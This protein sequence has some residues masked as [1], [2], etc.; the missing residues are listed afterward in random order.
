MSLLYIDKPKIDLAIT[1][2]VLQA[3]EKGEL[4]AQF[5][6]NALNGILIYGNSTISAKLI[7]KALRQHINLVFLY[8]NRPY[9]IFPAEQTNAMLRLRQYEAS[10]CKALCLRY[11]QYLVKS[12]T[13]RQ[14]LTLQHLQNAPAAK[15]LRSLLPELEKTLSLPSL[16]GIEGNLAHLYFRGIAEKLPKKWHFQ[17]RNK[18]PPK[19]PINALFSL[20][21]TMVQNELYIQLVGHG[22]DAQMG[23]YHQLSYHRAALACD[24]I[25]PLR[26]MIDEWIITTFIQNN[27]LTPKH[28]TT[29]S[30]ACQLGKT[31]RKTYFSAFS[32]L[33][34]KLIPYFDEEITQLKTFIKQPISINKSLFLSD[35]EASIKE[36]I[37]HA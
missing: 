21:Y 27:A 36:T 24:L 20:S 16:L 37:A 12:K 7:A 25:E 5:P 11:G 18:R 9:A 6:L 34:N 29:Q 33:K 13:E 3:R 28:F 17:G 2:N 1:S 26:A 22:F 32:H 31:A 10:Q 35:K 15:M 8:R 19:D 14:I 4:L 30:Q 23:F